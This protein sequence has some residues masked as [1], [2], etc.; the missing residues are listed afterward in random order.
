MAGRAGTPGVIPIAA[1]I[2]AIARIDRN[3]CWAGTS[4]G[5]LYRSSDGGLTWT[6]W[7]NPALPAGAIKSLHFVN[8]YQGFMLHNTGG[9]LGTIYH[10]NNGGWTWEALTT[11]TTAG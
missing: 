5:A 1:N 9:G 6:A 7:A 2:Q 4:G 10:T 11:P 8:P 3:I